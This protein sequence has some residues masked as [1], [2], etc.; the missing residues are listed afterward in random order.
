MILIVAERF[1]WTFDTMAR[2]SYLQLRAAL[3]YIEKRPGRYC[4]M[5]DPE[6]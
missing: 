4:I 6:S 5:I 3:R 2:L 1:G